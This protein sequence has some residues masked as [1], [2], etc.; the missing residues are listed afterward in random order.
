MNDHPLHYETITALSRRI[1]SGEL[2][3]VALTASLLARIEALNGPLNA[4]NLVTEK[5][6][7]AEA[8]A[9]E[10]LIQ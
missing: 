7:L 10:T 5:R 2:S 9:A 6:A 1:R 8:R 4:F 3:P